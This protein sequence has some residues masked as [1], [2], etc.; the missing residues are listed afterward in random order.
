MKHLEE[1]LVPTLLV[2]KSQNCPHCFCD[3]KEQ[4]RFNCPGRETHPGWYI[5]P[6]WQS[7]RSQNY[8]WGLWRGF[9]D[10][11]SNA[12]GPICSAGNGTRVSW[13]NYM[14]SK[15]PTSCP[16]SLV[17]GPQIPKA[18]GRVTMTSLSETSMGHILRYFFPWYLECLAGK[19]TLEECVESRVD[20]HALGQSSGQAAL[21]Q[22]L[23]DQWRENRNLCNE[24]R[25]GWVWA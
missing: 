23:L 15:C 7:F 13:S 8:S 12:Q 18:E 14:Q 19:D 11:L 10:T 22:F 21:K 1:C 24:F 2:T 3:D 20:S 17:P 6:K 9:G 4:S 5:V 25:D 16:V